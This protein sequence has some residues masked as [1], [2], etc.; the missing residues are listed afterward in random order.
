M[1]RKNMEENISHEE[2]MKEL[3]ETTEKCK[4]EMQQIDYMLSSKEFISDA[5]YNVYR[6]KIIRWIIAIISIAISISIIDHFHIHNKI[7]S[8]LCSIHIILMFLYPFPFTKKWVEKVKLYNERKKLESQKFFLKH[9]C[10][11]FMEEFGEKIVFESETN[12]SSET[13]EVLQ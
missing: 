2:K 6:K 3:R 5:E 9:I 13:S 1:G 8:T 11:D 10:I 12:K 4:K 7:I